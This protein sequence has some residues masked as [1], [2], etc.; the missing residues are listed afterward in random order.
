MLRSVGAISVGEQSSGISIWRG[1]AMVD[2]S[3][4]TLY[5]FTLGATGKTKLKANALAATYREFT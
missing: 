4:H 3:A 2:I 1:K 5:T